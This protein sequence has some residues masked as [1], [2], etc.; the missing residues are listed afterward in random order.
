MGLFY[1][2]LTVFDPPRESLV[3]TLKELKRTAYLSPT[4]HGYTVVYD[5]AIA[6]KPQVIEEVGTEL[7]SRLKC[8][9]LAAM[10]H[11]D[12]VLYLWLFHNGTLCDSY[13]S[14]PNYFV[15]AEPV[16][17][18]GGDSEMI[19]LAFKRPDRIRAVK[20]LLRANYLQHKLPKGW[21]EFERHKELAAEL[22]MPPLVS[23]IT[24]SSIAGDYVPKEFIPKEFEG[25]TFEA[26]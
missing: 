3:T 2:N 17:P 20:Q 13:D 23:G 15:Q 26:V 14:C 6:G 12:D 22:G 8:A 5:K 1:Q 9:A 18:R 7:T 16:P 21:G 25:I 19:C 11:D 24:Y 4:L 10:L